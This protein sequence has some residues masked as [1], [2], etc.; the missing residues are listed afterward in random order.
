M[1]LVH[2]KIRSRRNDT[3]QLW[4][5]EIPLHLGWLANSDPEEVTVV[6]VELT[7]VSCGG[8]VWWQPYVSLERHTAHLQLAATCQAG[9]LRYHQLEPSAQVFSVWRVFTCFHLEASW[10]SGHWDSSYRSHWIIWQL[11]VS[12]VDIYLSL[13]ILGD[14]FKNNFRH[15]LTRVTSRR[16]P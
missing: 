13:E 15:R 8:L 2:G 1:E 11:L 14:I 7:W 6:S 4:P 16:R 12:L 5:L 10:A 9:R 3:S